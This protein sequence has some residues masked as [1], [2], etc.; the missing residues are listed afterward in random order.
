MTSTDEIFSLLAS[1]LNN[2]VWFGLTKIPFKKAYADSS[3]YKLNEYL[4]LININQKREIK[5]LALTCID[6]NPKSLAINIC[7]P[8]LSSEVTRGQL[9][10]SL[11][12][13]KS[14]CKLYNSMDRLKDVAILSL[15]IQLILKTRTKR[16]ASYFKTIL[17][18]CS[19][20]SLWSLYIIHTW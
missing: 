7:K 20:I 14:I 17:I 13:I 10:S 1:D 11:Y 2:F 4:T 5:Q 6:I 12:F 19:V 18:S 9:L 16:I 3:M 8:L 15:Q